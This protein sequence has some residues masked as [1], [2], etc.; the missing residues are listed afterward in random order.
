[1]TTWTVPKEWARLNWTPHYPG[2]S[3]C[4]EHDEPTLQ[5]GPKEPPYCLACVRA[6][7]KSLGEKP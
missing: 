2:C 7:L 1:M 6:A 3:R 5:L 4:G